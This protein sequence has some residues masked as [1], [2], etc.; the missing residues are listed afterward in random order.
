MTGECDHAGNPIAERLGKAIEQLQKNVR[1]V[2]IWAG[3]LTAY[4]QPVADYAL[5]EQ[6][7]LPARPVEDGASRTIAENADSQ[8]LRQ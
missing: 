5:D 7:R 3:A 1:Q 2:E 6:Y 4:A 8:P